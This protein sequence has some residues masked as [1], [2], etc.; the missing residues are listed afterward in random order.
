[1]RK[2]LGKHSCMSSSFP[3]VILNDPFFRQCNCTNENSVRDGD[4]SPSTSNPIPTKLNYFYIYL[5]FKYIYRYKFDNVSLSLH[6]YSKW[7]HRQCGGLV[8]RRSHDRVWLSAASLVI[9]SPARIAVCNTWSSGGTALCRVGRATSQ[10]D[11]LSL[12]PLSVAGCGWLQL[13]APHWATS[14]NYCK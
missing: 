11:L 12:T 10:W 6:L 3:I 1:M 2:C 4:T 7:R 14:V 9:C 5:I 8:F 13:G